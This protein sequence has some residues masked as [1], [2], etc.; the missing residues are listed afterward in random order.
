M[1]VWGL[2]KGPIQLLR[3]CFKLQDETLEGFSSKL[4]LPQNAEAGKVTSFHA[5][6]EQRDRED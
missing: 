4:N 2:S 3:D 1:E 5:M 6:N